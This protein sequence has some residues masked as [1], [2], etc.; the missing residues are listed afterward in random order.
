M[1]LFELLT[2]R[3]A[4][5]MELPS[6]RRPDLKRAY[7]W[8][9]LFYWACQPRD[10]RYADATAM[11][12]AAKYEPKPLP[13]AAATIVTPQLDDP[14]PVE[15]SPWEALP[16][17]WDTL[18]EH[19]QRERELNV[20]IGEALWIY[21][22]K[23]PEVNK[24]RAAQLVLEA[25]T[26]AARERL[27]SHRRSVKDQ[28]T[29]QIASL[30]HNRATLVAEG[31][32]PNHPSVEEL[33]RAIDTLHIFE[34]NLAKSLLGKSPLGEL[35]RDWLTAKRTDTVRR[36]LEV[37]G[38]GPENPLSQLAK[39]KLQ[40]WEWY[41]F[42]LA[43]ILCLVILL[44][45]VFLARGCPQTV[46]DT[47]SPAPPHPIVPLEEFPEAMARPSDSTA[48]GPPQEPTTD[49]PPAA[50][51]AAAI[52]EA[53]ENGD[54]A[55]VIALLDQG[56]DVNARSDDDATP[57]CK[58][59]YAGDLAM[60]KLLV[61]RGANID[62]TT[63]VGQT[64]L[65]YT[66]ALGAIGVAKFLLE[67][68]ADVDAPNQTGN[69]PLAQAAYNGYFDLVELF[70]DNGAEVNAK[71]K[72]N[73]SPVYWAVYE[74]HFEIVGLLLTRGANPNVTNDKARTPLSLAIDMGSDEVIDLLKQ[75][76]AK[77]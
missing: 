38:S 27:D 66:T 6:Q 13:S 53:A 32:L 14:T 5:G 21:E 33:D 7:Y 56:G 35:L 12:Q 67:Q 22:E 45:L 44:C 34:E 41:P 46:T 16:I 9:R 24:L 74:D 15:G 75:Y 2:G 39:S 59:A 61:E 40:G 37:H 52:I 18:W 77:E 65:H 51:A 26:R 31:C 69:T 29:A 55:K 70:L 43:M 30:E 23:H 54:T 11:L 25:N 19:R 68:G 57:L 63:K 60:A 71:N 17:H 50:S 3:R 28:L 4:A 42:P 64:A 36:F 76:G 62:A 8:D 10:R 1:L 49:A 20:R 47:A 73:N 58:A 72:T 48:E